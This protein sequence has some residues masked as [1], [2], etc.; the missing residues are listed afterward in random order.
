MAKNH[1]ELQTHMNAAHP[2]WLDAA[3]KKILGTAP[4]SN[5]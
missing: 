5:N 1:A 2:G 3:V 4:Q